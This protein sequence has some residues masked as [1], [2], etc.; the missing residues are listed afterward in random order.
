MRVS[1]HAAWGCLGLKRQGYKVLSS[2]GFGHWNL[3]FAWVRTTCA[4]HE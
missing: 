4:S 2:V 3:G 1:I